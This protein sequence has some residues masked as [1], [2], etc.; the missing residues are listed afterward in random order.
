MRCVD[1]AWGCCA[2]VLLY[3]LRCRFIVSLIRC[4]RGSLLIAASV[5]I[6]VVVLRC[7]LAVLVLGAGGVD[8]SMVWC[9]D[10]VSC[11]CGV[12]TLCCCCCAA[13]LLR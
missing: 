2:A 5:G 10:A 1:A 3:V 6:D 8:V 13:S 7:W 9:C 4:F 11:C 12:V